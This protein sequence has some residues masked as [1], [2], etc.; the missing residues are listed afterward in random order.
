[1]ALARGEAEKVHRL[2]S[3]IVVEEVV[4]KE[5]SFTLH[6]VRHSAGS[7]DA[8]SLHDSMLEEPTMAKY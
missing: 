4:E 3:A 6:G 1:M 7:E 8:R 2:S 5:T